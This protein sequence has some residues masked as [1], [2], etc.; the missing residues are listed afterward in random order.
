MDAAR[1][2]AAFRGAGPVSALHRPPRTV[3]EGYALQ[4]A[5]RAELG[6]A[7]I[8]W[9]LDYS[10]RTAGGS[11]APTVAPLM[12][13]MVVPAETMFGAHTFYAPEV[14]AEIVLET[15]R[16]LAGPRRM[17]EVIAALRGMRIAADIADT[18]YADKAAMD[19]PALIGDLGGAGAL[20]IGPLFDLGELHGALTT[21]PTVRLGD[22]S[23]AAALPRELRPNP[24]EAVAFLT[25]FLA[26]R[27]LDLPAGSLVATGAQSVPTRSSAG[28]IAIGF[29]AMMRVRARLSTPRGG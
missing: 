5:V 14:G 4:D 18:R 6:R 19:T 25:G 7:V 22:G 13:G 10:A 24:I 17:E 16:A 11:E 9:K 3:A 27:G 2:A 12:E 21:A 26:E 1:L 29:G 8:G 23:M 20:V 28:K 15:G